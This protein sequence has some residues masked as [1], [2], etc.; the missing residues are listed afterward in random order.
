MRTLL[1]FCAVALVGITAS[2]AACGGNVVVDD[3]TGSGGKPSA[4]GNGGAL[5]SSTASVG[6][7]I[8][9]GGAFSASLSSAFTGTGA[10]GPS[11][12]SGVFA[13]A[14]VSSSTVTAVSATTTTVASSSASSASSSSGC[15][16]G[17]TQ[18]ELNC[19]NMFHPAYVTF[20]GFAEK[21]CA[22]SSVAQSPCAAFCPMG[23]PAPG[24]E[25]SC[26]ACTECVFQQV[27]QGQASQCVTR[28][29]LNECVPDPSC[30][31]F[32]QCA[33]NCGGG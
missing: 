23:C 19:A 1:G 6:G 12:T 7:D 15:S 32:V 29:A 21:E 24:Q 14:T 17:L 13:S 28:A 20:M 26:T 5:P 9:M 2:A 27:D 33:L 30:A 18:C 3:E 10:D 8:G 22:C 4:S 11:A 25:L 16:T 31:P